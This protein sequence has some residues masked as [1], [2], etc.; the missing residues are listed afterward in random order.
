MSINGIQGKSNEEMIQSLG[1]EGS[2]VQKGK[3]GKLEGGGIVGVTYE[4]GDKFVSK[5]EEMK[6]GL[7]AEKLA[8]RG[9]NALNEGFAAMDGAVNTSSKAEGTTSVFGSYKSVS[10]F[11]V[12]ELMKLLIQAFSTLMSTQRQADLN[13]LE[14]IVTTLAAKVEAMED[15]KEAQYKSTLTNAIGSIVAGSVSVVFAAGSAIA[16][17]VGLARFKNA[18]SKFKSTAKE[19]SEAAQKASEEAK[20]ASEAAKD[21][22]S[23]VAKSATTIDMPEK[24][25]RAG[26][27]WTIGG[28]AAGESAGGLNQITMGIT[29]IISAGQAADKA[30]AEIRQ[31]TADAM[32]EVWRKAQDQGQKSTE[33]LMQF[34]TSLLN[35]MQQLQQSVSATEKAVVQS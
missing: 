33:S 34:I 23:N 14:G 10:D 2:K 21:T 1:N 32:L 7:M 9:M 24:V 12:R 35:M 4:D 15:A 19:A 3:L 13:T 17:G 11:D 22:A 8:E 26:E 28:K 27:G 18:A 31:T 30:Q 5:R 25:K 6:G 29:N 20:G 16:S